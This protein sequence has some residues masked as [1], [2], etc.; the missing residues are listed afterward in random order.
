MI[1]GMLKFILSLSVLFSCV[2][3]SRD[4]ELHAYENVCDIVEIMRQFPDVERLSLINCNNLVNL[5]NFTETFVNLKYLDVSGS[6]SMIYAF[7][8]DVSGAF[9]VLEYLNMSN[10]PHLESLVNGSMNASFT[11]LF[12]LKFT[13]GSSL[14][15]GN[16]SDSLNF[17]ARLYLDSD[18]RYF[19]MTGSIENSFNAVP[20]LTMN[21]SYIAF[22]DIRD[23]FYSLQYMEISVTSS[24][25]V[26]IYNSFMNVE[27]LLIL[28]N[29]TYI[30]YYIEYG[31]VYTSVITFQDMYYLADALW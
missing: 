4:A 22:E 2:M 25:C 26:G 14:A 6:S 11:S 3:S 20:A 31:F 7:S 8:G 13:N 9:P 28:S 30:A 10:C 1:G 27:T 17:L 21:L 23:S 16:I 5:D 19:S 12:E 24:L 18:I 15:I 29:I